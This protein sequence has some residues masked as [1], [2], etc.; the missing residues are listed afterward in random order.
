EYDV[1]FYIKKRELITLLKTLPALRQISSIKENEE[2]F[3]FN[4]RSDQDDEII[5]SKNKQLGITVYSLFNINEERHS[6]V[7]NIKSDTQNRI[8]LITIVPNNDRFTEIDRLLEEV[9]R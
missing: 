7:E 8:D 9:R 6:L 4:I 5:P 3:D 1:E 2:S